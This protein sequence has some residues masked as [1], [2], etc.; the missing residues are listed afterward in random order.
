MGAVPL[1][2]GVVARYQNGEAALRCPP[3]PA[4]LLTERS[5]R[6]RKSIHDAG[7]ES[8][9]VD[10]QFERVR[11]RHAQQFAAEKLSLDLASLGWQVPA[12]IGA[13][14]ILQR[15]ADVATGTRR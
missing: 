11:G 7:V 10:S 9:D 1:V 6:A 14:P 4:D 13:T 3:G 2:E 12:P 5:H 8:A 15:G